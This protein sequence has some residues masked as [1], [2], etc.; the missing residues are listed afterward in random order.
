IPERD[1][2]R[3]QSGLPFLVAVS[4]CDQRRFGFSIG[5]RIGSPK[6]HNQRPSLGFRNDRAQ[7]FK[8]VDGG[9]VDGDDPIATLE[10]GLL[11]R[12]IRHDTSEE[13]WHVGQA[14]GIRTL[15]VSKNLGYAR[16]KTI[17]LWYVNQIAITIDRHDK[18][19]RSDRFRK[20]FLE[21][22]KRLTVDSDE[23]VTGAQTEVVEDRTVADVE[24]ADVLDRYVGITLGE[25]KPGENHGGQDE[26][27]DY[28]GSDDESLPDLLRPRLPGLRFRLREVGVHAL[29]HHPRDL[30]IATEWRSAD[31]IFGFTDG[32]TS[33]LW[34][35]PDRELLDAHTEHARGQEVPQL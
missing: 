23:P 11:C 20:Y 22:L 16:Q 19:V 4:I 29:V 14:Q 12:G 27:E 28:T 2:L 13:A 26:V 9:S 25:L 32:L 6:V 7:L 31:H 15:G 30:D 17:G 10:A 24:S 21:T 18:S 8:V 1:L 34:R 5:Q 3:R 35:E 33:D